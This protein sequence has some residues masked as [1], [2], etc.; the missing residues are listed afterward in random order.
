MVNVGVIGLGMMGATHLEVYAKRKDVRIVAVSDK[1]PKLLS[2]EIQ[3]A[4]NVEGQASGGVDLSGVKRY[5]EGLDLIADPDIQLVDVCL[6][7]PLHLEYGKA[8]LE[9]GKH[10]FLEK[11][12]A[13]TA[14]K[15]LELAE[16]AEQAPGI[17]MPA[18][19]IRFWPEW[20]W[21]KQQ[22]DQQTYGAVRSANFRRLASHPGG[23]FYSNGDASGG[24]ILDLH[25][26][27]TD[28]IQHCF[29]L[30]KSV[31]SFG[32]S[33]VTNQ[34]DHVVT[35]YQYDDIPLVSAEGGWAM[36]DGFEFT[37]QYTVNFEEA[38]AVYDLG[39]EDPLKVFRNDCEPQVISVPEGIGYDHEIAYLLEC[40]ETGSAPSRVTMHDAAAALRIV[41]AEIE[42]IRQGGASQVPKS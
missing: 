36:Q 39:A 2:G 27:D 35:H 1:N 4:G 15:A 24:A 8:V 10:L 33:K 19:C 26:H 3:A 30:P 13:R 25:I 17:A 34:I 32:Y 23:S 20:H 41:E 6:P 14:E 37:M 16:L 5:E 31:T 29:G 9:A 12:L 7:T 11:P 38:T 18:M 22:I 40:I 28:F 21:L 42:S